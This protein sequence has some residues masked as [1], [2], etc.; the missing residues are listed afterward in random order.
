MNATW[1][2]KSQT[3]LPTNVLEE[4]SVPDFNWLTAG[5]PDI[6]PALCTELGVFGPL[7]LFSKPG[8]PM[9]Q[10]VPVAPPLVG[11]LHQQVVVLTPD[12]VG[13]KWL[14]CSLGT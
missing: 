1:T 11:V 9:G 5:F 4:T 3:P 14:I 7:A 13:V 2:G 10:S 12:L 6:V 8:P